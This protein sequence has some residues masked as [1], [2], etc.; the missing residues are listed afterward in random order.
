VNDPIRLSRRV[1]MLKGCSRSE[2]EQLIEGGWV[3]VDGRVVEEP[4]ERVLDETIEI[5]PAARPTPAEPVTF[6]LNKLPGV[7]AGVAPEQRADDDA[8][9]VRPLKRHFPR[10]VIPMALPAA[11][12]G[13][14]V[15]TQDGR[16]IRRLT[17][18]AALVEEEWIVQVAGVIAPE[19]VQRLGRDLRGKASVNSQ[20]DTEARLRIAAKGV[21]PGRLPALCAAAGLQVLG[22]KR[23]RLGRVP[24]GQLAPGRWRYLL[25][26]ERF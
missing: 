9:G 2:A 5:D 26:H 11:A 22:L 4:Q 14:A 24:L 6:L 12:T 3:R 7:P 10:L 1:A 20:S 8:S 16:V 13:L 15:L 17:E 18:D 19:V 21:P 23:L 25:P